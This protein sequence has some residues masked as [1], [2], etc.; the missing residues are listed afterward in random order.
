MSSDSSVNLLTFGDH[1]GIG[2]LVSLR[3]DLNGLPS[4]PCGLS[5]AAFVVGFASLGMLADWDLGDPMTVYS[6][7]EKFTRFEP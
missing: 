7:G 5:N 6:H 1:T 3:I 2:E 4:L